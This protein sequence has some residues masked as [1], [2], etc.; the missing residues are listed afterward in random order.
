M[1]GGMTAPAPPSRKASA[2]WAL[3][4]AAATLSTVGVIALAAAPGR[5]DAMAAVYPPWWSPAR[6]AASA[7][8][9]GRLQAIGGGA[10]ILI[11]SSD[12]PDLARRLRASGALLLLDSRLASFCAGSSPR[13][14]A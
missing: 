10:T 2:T 4:L 8:A 6:A 3:P 9:E 5:A 7:A 14:P 1:P 13:D 12:K 11:V